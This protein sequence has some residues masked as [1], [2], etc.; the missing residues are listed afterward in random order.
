MNITRSPTKSPHLKLLSPKPFSASFSASF[1]AA[2]A[3]RTVLTKK[4]PISRP[5][6]AFTRTMATNKADGLLQ[7][8]KDR[9]SYYVLTKDLTVSTD[10]V[11]EIVKEALAQVPS[12]FNSQ[13]NR[14]VVL[15]GADH[16]KL[17]DITTEILKAIV[18]AEGWEATAGKLGLFKGAAGSVS[19]LFF[20]LPFS[21]F[22]FP[23]V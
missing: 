9:R 16:E 11:Q 22:F 4:K 18:P 15:F 19:S 2:A 20:F 21:S 1:S 6:A 3:T 10:R 8:L 17:W 5:T 23:R 14:A 7:L 13:S 12:S